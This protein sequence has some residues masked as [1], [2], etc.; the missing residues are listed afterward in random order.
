MAVVDAALLVVVLALEV[1][2]DIV[3]D[4]DACEGASFPGRVSAVAAVSVVMVIVGGDG[5]HSRGWFGGSNYGC[6][7]GVVGVEEAIVAGGEA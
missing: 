6:D 7:G 2:A 3:W 4:V 1:V 5:G